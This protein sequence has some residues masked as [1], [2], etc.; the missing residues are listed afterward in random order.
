MSS[1][2]AWSNE[3]ATLCE[4]YS[5]HGY[6]WLWAWFYVPKILELSISCVPPN[7]DR[8]NTWSKSRCI[9]SYIYV[10]LG[11]NAHTSGALSHGIDHMVP[12]VSFA[13]RHRTPSLCISF[14]TNAIWGRGERAC[15]NAAFFI[16]PSTVPRLTTKSLV[17]ALSS[18]SGFRIPHTPSLYF[19]DWDMPF[20]E[21]FPVESRLQ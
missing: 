9:G 12:L 1:A 15:D 21:N 18:T 11:L 20:E 6:N 16:L 3:C 14:D 13:I 10:T 7:P 19:W 4:P 8:P 17:I 5:I 2:E